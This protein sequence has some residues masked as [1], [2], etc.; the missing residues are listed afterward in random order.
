MCISAET[1]LNGTMY[2]LS[3]S[4]TI[5]IIIHH[6]E[7]L[8]SKKYLFVNSTHLYISFIWVL[9]FAHYTCIHMD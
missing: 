1:W 2:L 4:I 5:C 7:N 9:S 3:S 6:K 8:Y